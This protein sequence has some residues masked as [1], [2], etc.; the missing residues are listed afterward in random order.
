MVI[1]EQSLYE[2][3][4]QNKPMKNKDLVA[5]SQFIRSISIPLPFLIIL[6]MIVGYVK[7]GNIGTLYGILVATVLS[8]VV[9][10]ITTAFTDTIGKSTSGMLYGQGKS[11]IKLQERLEGDLQQARFHKMNHRYEKALG[12]VDGALDQDPDFPDALFLKAQILWEGFQDSR[13][14]KECI[15]QIM[16]LLPT[17]D[18]PLY[19]WSTYLLS[20]INRGAE[21]PEEQSAE[22]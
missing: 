19:R 4:D 10:L 18:E 7:Y 12:F 11:T 16:Q 22:F 13:A 6:G 21:S 3:P 5:R 2:P 14:A 15:G 20:E 8:I 1:V 9:G 17:T